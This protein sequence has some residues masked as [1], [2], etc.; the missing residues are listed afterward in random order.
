MSRTGLHV[1]LER[2]R[3][4]LIGERQIGRQSP[5]RELRRVDRL[6]GIMLQQPL[7]EVTSNADISLPNV[8]RALEQRNVMHWTPFFAEA[9]K[10]TLL[11]N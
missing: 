10:G 1:P 2:F 8:A 5:R 11:R 9:S 3:L 6:A 4:G 7:A